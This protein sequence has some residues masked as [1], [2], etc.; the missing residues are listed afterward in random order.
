M[1]DLAGLRAIKHVTDSTQGRVGLDFESF[2]TTI[3][4]RGK[5]RP[6]PLT[7]RIA[8]V[9]VYAE[10]QTWY[11]SVRHLGDNCPLL[12]VKVWLGDLFDWGRTSQRLW[13]WNLAYELQI[14]R[15]EG[16]DY[17][18]F[19]D[20]FNDGM[21]SGWLAGWGRQ[22]KLKQ[23]TERIF[24]SLAPLPDFA[25]TFGKDAD[26]SQFAAEQ[27]A[28]YGAKDPWLTCLLA[29]ASMAEVARRDLARHYRD[30]DMPMVEPLRDQQEFGV[31]V[32][33]P[34]L[35]ALRVRKRA[36][37]VAHAE[38][39][40][41]RTTTRVKLS[42]KVPEV[43]L[44]DDGL[45]VI[46][47]SGKRKGEAKTRLV[48]RLIEVEAGA[49]VASDAQVARWMY[50]ELKLWP[51]KGLKPGKNGKLPVDRETIERFVTLGNP[52]ATEMV[53]LVLGYRRADKL[54]STY[55]DVCIEQPEQWGDNRLHPS[56]HL[57]GTDTQRLSSS[58][59]SF[60]NIPVHS[61]DAKTVAAAL[62]A[63]TG[64]KY[65]IYDMSQIEMRIMAHASKDPALLSAYAWGDD[66]HAR[67]LAEVRKTFS[68]AE[69]VTAKIT[70]FSTI[71]RIGA[72]SLAVK[73][74]SDEA[75]AQRFIDAFYA[76]HV[77]IAPYHAKVIRFLAKH[78]YA[79]TLDGFRR[80]LD[81]SLSSRTNE[82]RWGECNKAISTSIQG[83]A[84]G[85]IKIAQRNLHRRWVK[86]G[87]YRKRVRFAGQIHDSLLACATDAFAER[88]AK[89][90]E[91]EMVNAVKLIVPLEASGAVGQSWADCKA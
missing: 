86:A 39:F 42:A 26:M 62:L 29:D 66:V 71:Y 14:C 4:W 88:A 9:G 37:A 89:D 65:V 21:V 12:A 63:P 60:Q 87:E 34:A 77:G 25:Q 5:S 18:D 7:H 57:T 16:V 1:R 32:D 55:L 75:T 51:T 48:E 31:G 82:P 49:D 58:G 35:E 80:Y 85:I 70:N 81:G 83:S 6:N 56:Y 30:I 44:G 46:F 90:M 36:E 67:T 33:R 2:G 15:N 40:K 68:E 61:E 41:A 24:P 45:P 13:F 47:K 28:P 54:C 84:G 11:V 52:V 17:G 91:Y 59:P 73:I 79:P 78:G 3:R 74:K 76:A 23:T 22:L 10:G 27:V 50:E 19:S 38:M 8:G 53:D 20:D 43:V 72:Q 64:W 69:R